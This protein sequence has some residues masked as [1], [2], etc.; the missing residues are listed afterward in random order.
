VTRMASQLLFSFDE[1][2]PVAPSLPIFV[3][4]ARA[5]RYVLRLLRDGTPRVT[6]PRWGSKREAEAFLV[7]Q[8]AWVLRERQRQAAR[9]A[10][11]PPREWSDGH[12]LL[13]RGRALTL[14]R[15]E[16]SSPGV[17]TS[18][19]TLLVTPARAQPADL[20]TVVCAWL[21][22]QA[23]QDLPGQ[24]RALAAPLGLEVATVSVRNQRSRWGSCSS[25]GR[26][27][28][29]WRLVQTPD[30][31]RDYVLIH[32]LMHLRQPNHS[33]R[34]W[35]LVADACPGHREARGWLREHEALLLD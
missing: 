25:T 14:R 2:G 8:A 19:D 22:Q 4:N 34:F 20:R 35:A 12:A 32:E 29:N 18:G 11:R 13:V 30:M 21:W 7:S 9:Q 3:R 17:L 28:L 33:R 31:V 5:R 15:H 26:I 10:H 1:P 24:L 27:S 23:R 6:I 16:G